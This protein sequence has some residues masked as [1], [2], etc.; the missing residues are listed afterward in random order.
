[1]NGVNPEPDK[2]L[3]YGIEWTKKSEQ[4]TKVVK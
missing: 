2:T 1:M 4:T 3:R